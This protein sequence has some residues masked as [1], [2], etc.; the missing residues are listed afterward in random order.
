MVQFS[1][2]SGNYTSAVTLGTRCTNH[3]PPNLLVLVF[4]YKCAGL[5]LL[6]HG[7]VSH[8]LRFGLISHINAEPQ[9]VS[10]VF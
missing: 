10:G 4:Q 8:E 3:G 1:G 6:C 5:L 7:S 2:R 9:T